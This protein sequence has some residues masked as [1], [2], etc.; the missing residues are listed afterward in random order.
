LLLGS[1]PSGPAPVL[2][3]VGYADSAAP[4]RPLRLAY[5]DPSYPGKAWLYRDHPD[6]GGEVNHAELI[7]RLVAY[8]GWALSTSAEALPAVL[9]LCPVVCVGELRVVPGRERTAHTRRLRPHKNALP[10]CLAAPGTFQPAHGPCVPP[11][12]PSD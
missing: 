11:L 1:L 8:D 12:P 10:P 6:Y 5:A 7:D 4:G 9:A 2:R 3:A